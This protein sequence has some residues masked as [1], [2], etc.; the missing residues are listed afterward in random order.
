MKLDKMSA[1]QL[2][3]L[4]VDVD[5]ALVDRQ[6]QDLADAKAAAEAAVAEF[7]FSLADLNTKPKG[8]TRAKAAPKYRNPD[9]AEQTWT[10]RGR[11]PQWII[12]ALT[13]GADIAALE[14]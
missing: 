9:N 11:K 12:D 14:I 2:K 8:G 10:G 4:R 13:A 1:V 5:A 7:G 3:Q 6:R